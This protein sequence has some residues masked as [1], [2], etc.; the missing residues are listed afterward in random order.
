MT[1]ALFAFAIG[2]SLVST[3]M[4]QGTQT[5][6]R[7]PQAS[8]AAAATPPAP[9]GR[10]S[11][12]GSVSSADAGAQ[13]IRLATVVLIGATTGTLKVTMTDANGVFRFRDLPADHYLVGA[14]KRPY[15]G[16]VAGAT[17]PGRPGA[18]VVVADGQSVANVAIKLTPG[19]A[20]GGTVLDDR[21]H[22]ALGVGVVV[23]QW[24]TRGGERTLMTVPNG[25]AVT[26]D[27]GVYRVF[28]LMPGQY[29]V[30]AQPP[31]VP[32]GV[33]LHDADVDRAL[34]GGAVQN[35]APQP[36]REYAA[37]YA[38]GSTMSPADAMTI[39][40]SPGDDRDGVDM[41]L[42]FVR[43]VKIDGTLIAADGQPVT[44]GVLSTLND[45]PAQPGR[46]TPI[47]AGGRFQMMLR[48]GAQTLQFVSRGP[49]PAQVGIGSIDV[50]DTD[51]SG[52]QV[53][54][55][56]GLTLAGRLAFDSTTPPPA[57]GG[58]PIPLHAVSAAA[59]SAHR[60]PLVLTNPSG[61]FTAS[62]L[63]PGQYIV[64]GPM[65][66][67]ASTDSI[68]WTIRSVFAGGK[69]VTDLPIVV[70]ADAAPP[71][72]VVTLTDA[73]QAVSGK[74]DGAPANANYT[75]VIF[76]AD[77]TYW[78]PGSRRIRTTRAGSD[79]TFA[80]G[81][82]GSTS[83][84]AGSYLL[85]LVT[86]IDKDEEFDPAFLDSI[87]N[88]ATPVAIAPGAKVTQNVRIR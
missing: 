75:V 69:D 20:I 10:A 71:E 70:T 29:V 62:N 41:Q 55:R 49:G 57:I 87:V 82:P 86:D 27:R 8:R 52:V 22:P 15:I 24:R 43:L 61:A 31:S 58:R 78:I 72:V 33:P 77:K 73:W 48:P 88:A 1:R 5:P 30:Y 79:G 11:M 35:P 42:A 54:L 7:D 32:A 6:V 50:G 39:D 38:P 36:A 2:A 80:I 17:R 40:L 85:A 3:T 84:P 83:L 16:A 12:T 64:S 25:T 14:S 63:L 81:G 46:L 68:K 19:A 47:P 4:A 67:G 56:P 34:A 44:A 53:S 74:I 65:S 23:K 21:G 51:Q 45:D 76:P 28:G 59:E 26:D 60:T 37:V 13:P 9:A 18:S 66:F